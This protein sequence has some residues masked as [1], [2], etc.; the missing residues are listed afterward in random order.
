MD[1]NLL[2]VEGPIQKKTIY[3]YN[4]SCDNNRNRVTHLMTSGEW[5]VGMDPPVS[6]NMRP[7]YSRS[8]RSRWSNAAYKST[9]KEHYRCMLQIKTSIQ[10]WYYQYILQ[11]RQALPQ[12]AQILLLFCQ[13]QIYGRYRQGTLLVPESDQICQ[14]HGT[15]GYKSWNI[16]II[17][18]HSTSRK[19]EVMLFSKS[20]LTMKILPVISTRCPWSIRSSM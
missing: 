14:I 2:C 4:D 12:L 7:K 15:H 11:K 20:Y 13:D 19:N 3:Y 9:M 17:I 18:F 5:P 6:L 1:R 16:N 10:F 8:C